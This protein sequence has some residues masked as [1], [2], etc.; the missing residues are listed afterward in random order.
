MGEFAY[1]HSALL[2][3]D[4]TLGHEGAQL[5]RIHGELVQIFSAINVDVYFL[6]S[7]QT[8][9][10]DLSGFEQY[11]LI[12]LVGDAGKLFT[13]KRK[14]PKKIPELSVNLS[15]IRRR[16][17]N[18]NWLSTVRLNLV[19]ELNTN[20]R[21][22]GSKFFDATICVKSE[23]EEK[24]RNLISMAYKLLQ[25]FTIPSTFNIDFRDLGVIA[26]GRGVA[27]SLSGDDPY[28]I[29]SKLPECCFTARCGLNHFSCSE[30]VNLNEIYSIS[31]II[32]LKRANIQEIG[33]RMHDGSVKKIRNLNLKFGIRI[34]ENPAQV[35]DSERRNP[36]AH[37][38]IPVLSYLSLGHKRIEMTTVLFGIR[39]SLGFWK[40]R[41]YRKL[42]S[43]ASRQS[44]SK[45]PNRRNRAS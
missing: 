32:A 14:Q 24:F 36:D 4:E 2:I 22:R 44:F 33:S 12:A 25:A 45:L 21:R 13:P 15:P 17:E 20:R 43:E 28:Q 34:R 16:K 9:L 40:G 38:S 18:R 26:K 11:D 5:D 35:D 10:A 19:S 37:S 1:P 3:D 29:I 27:L 30:D 23:T 6:D 8:R 42:V 7:G 31:K 39:G 41:T